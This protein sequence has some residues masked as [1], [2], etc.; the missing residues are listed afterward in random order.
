M[1][2]DNSYYCHTRAVISHKV[3]Q[4]YQNPSS[5]KY[6]YCIHFDFSTVLHS[7]GSKYLPAY[8]F[9][10]LFICFISLCS[11]KRSGER[12]CDELLVYGGCHVSEFNIQACFGCHVTKM[13]PQGHSLQSK[14]LFWNPI[15]TCCSTVFLCGHM[16]RSKS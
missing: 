10:Y 12:Q 1:R 2:L 9:I 11:P 4:F 7:E 5:S 8:L 16:S 15:I 14:I 6:L 3:A 13:K